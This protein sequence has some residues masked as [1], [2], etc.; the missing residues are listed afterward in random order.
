MA[1]SSHAFRPAQQRGARA[2]GRHAR[3]HH[4]RLEHLKVS[5][6]HRARRGARDRHL[7]VALARPLAHQPHVH[8]ARDALGEDREL[9]AAGWHGRGGCERFAGEKC[10]TLCA[11]GCGDYECALRRRHA[12][13]RHRGGEAHGVAHVQEAHGLG[14]HHAHG[15][16]SVLHERE[17]QTAEV[18]GRGEAAEGRVASHHAAGDV[19]RRRAADDT[20]PGLFCGEVC[21][22]V[23]NRAA[24]RELE[25]HRVHGHTLGGARKEPHG[26]D[27][28]LTRPERGVVE[29]CGGGGRRRCLSPPVRAA[30]RHGV[31][32]GCTAAVVAA[33]ARKVA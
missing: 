3:L 4:E 33:L 21:D 16:K 25:R 29:R 12:L 18:E 17:G 7:H 6:L 24:P 28:P 1:E 32:L 9:H 14:E 2:A 23:R 5:A 15:R 20:L 30:L 31:Q 8:R 13:R 19:E 11:R 10:D 27:R 22:V 26:K